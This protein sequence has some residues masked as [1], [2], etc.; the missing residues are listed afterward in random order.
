MMVLCYQWQHSLSVLNVD[1]LKHTCTLESHLEPDVKSRIIG[2]KHQMS[3]FDFFIGVSLGERILKHTDNLSKT[4]Q[5]KDI[6]ASEG[7]QVAEL[8]V[9]TLQSMRNDEVYE[10]FWVTAQQ[11]ASNFDIGE[12]TLP[13]KRKAP[14]HFEIG[15]SV[16][17][18]PSSPKDHYKRIYFEAFD[19]VINCIKNRF[20]QPGYLMYRNL[21]TVLISAANGRDFEE[22]LKV[23][24]D[25][26]DTDVTHSRLKAQLEILAVHF[27]STEN[28]SWSHLAHCWQDV[29]CSTPLHGKFILQP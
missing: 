9:K 20:D 23:V 19:L 22:H 21:E 18:F 27:E 1:W 17:E 3:T 16:S 29:K 5:H 26:Y 10:L 25:F 6:S 28:V 4:L 14:R 12:P 11:N 8:S 15:S 13:R 24:T 7:Q 2:V